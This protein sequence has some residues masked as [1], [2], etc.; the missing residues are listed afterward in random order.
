M[1]VEQMTQAQVVHLMRSL[2]QGPVSLQVSRQETRLSNDDTISVLEVIDNY[3]HVIY[4]DSMVTGTS[5]S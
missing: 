5:S 3:D 2:P 1:T 4:C